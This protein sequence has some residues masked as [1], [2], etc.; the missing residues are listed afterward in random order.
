MSSQCPTESALTASHRAP[1]ISVPTE[2]NEAASHRAGPPTAFPQTET[3]T[4]VGVR[5]PKRRMQRV[6]VRTTNSATKDDGYSEDEHDDF[7]DYFAEDLDDDGDYDGTLNENNVPSVTAATNVTVASELIVEAPQVVVASLSSAAPAT[8][9]LH[10]LNTPTPNS[11]NSVARSSHIGALTASLG[12]REPIQSTAASSSRIPKTTKTKHSSG[13]KD[14]FRIKPEY[15]ALME[16][17]ILEAL[18]R[19]QLEPGAKKVPFHGQKD[20]SLNTLRN[21]RKHMK[22]FQHF[23]ALIGDHESL[24]MLLA[25]PPTPIC[26][27]MQPETIASFI[28]YK[29]SP[30]NTPLLDPAGTAIVDVVHGQPIMCQGGWNDPMS[31]NSF[32]SVISGIHRS[33]NQGGPFLEDCPRCKALETPPTQEP[34][35]PAVHQ[36][37]PSTT[38]AS[39]GCHAHRF[40][41]MLYR[42]GNPLHCSTVRDALHNSSDAAATYVAEGDT[43]LTPWELLDVRRRLLSGNSL[44]ELMIW[45]MVLIGAKLFLRSAEL[46][47]LQFSSELDYNCINWDLTIFQDNFI[48]GLCI[49]VKGKKDHQPVHLILWA[50]HE[51]PSLCPVRHLLL[52]IHMSGLKSGHLFPSAEFLRRSDRGSHCSEK[53]CLTYSSFQDYFKTL[54]AEVIKREGKFGSHSIRK[55]GYVLAIWGGGSEAEIMHCA[56]HKSYIDAKKY[57]QDA[58]F[59]LELSKRTGEDTRSLVATWHS[60]R[61]DYQRVPRANARRPFDQDLSAAAYYFF[62]ELCCISLN[63]PHRS[64]LYCLESALNYKQPISVGDEITREL[65]NIAPE[66]AKRLAALLQRAIIQARS[67]LSPAPS[68]LT[69]Q[70]AQAPIAI[71]EA[72][73]I[74]TAVAPTSV[75]EGMESV[76]VTAVAAGPM[77][78]SLTSSNAQ[79]DGITRSLSSSSFRP[80]CSGL[81]VFENAA[82]GNN[83]AQASCSLVI[84]PSVAI[85]LNFPISVAVPP[86][87][88]DSVPTRKRKRGGGCDLPGRS[89]LSKAKTGAEKLALIQ[90]LYDQLPTDL[91][92]LIDSVR[93]SVRNEVIPIFKCLKHHFQDNTAEFVQKWGSKGE[94][95]G[96]FSHSEFK[97][98]CCSGEKETCDKEKRAT[99]SSGKRQRVDFERT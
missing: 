80:D 18:K 40:R 85:P 26:P 62:V 25:S 75:V 59:L 91:S 99:R 51:N 45:T 9:D 34:E 87:V 36:H 92:E 78:D 79:L 38:A 27:S 82:V 52:Y 69:S 90:S 11:S 30:P 71:R 98:L 73:T 66:T 50:D 74:M 81:S 8:T 97:L 89:G 29:R 83:T 96:N 58:A 24:L 55:T 60:N 3:T 65:Q 56:R 41:P 70:P 17:G 21:Y 12:G 14:P 7:G 64:I 84:P 22:G 95:N 86:F 54:C 6:D 1:L 72:G 5:S 13:T 35:L 20:V 19:L 23:C 48:E 88:P 68:I 53:D 49:K 76:G 44:W 77:M 93:T 63:N 46:L 39:T 57:K 16:G 28:T 43:G 31:A 33:R 10:R 67:A 15:E 2:K 47:D 42:M 32:V 4:F 94:A 61:N 37:E